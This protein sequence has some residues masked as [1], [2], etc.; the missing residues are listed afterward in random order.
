MASHHLTV[1]QASADLPCN[2]LKTLSHDWRTYV[3]TDGRADGREGKQQRGQIEGELERTEEE[4]G[5]ERGR[6]EGDTDRKGN[7]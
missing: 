5:G 1:C 7:P 6:R 4:D 3:A 2:S